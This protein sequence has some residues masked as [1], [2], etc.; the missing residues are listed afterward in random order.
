VP[1]KPLGT[2]MSE[3]LVE[4]TSNNF[5]CVGIVDR[6]GS[7]VGIITDGDLRRHMRPDLITAPVDEI[8]TKNPKTI[9][10]E[11]LASEALEILNSGKITTL[12]VTSGRKPIGILRLHDLL[13]AGV[14]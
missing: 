14:A 13:H 10:P 12:I 2:S 11:M 8:M 5:G 1:L 7:I 4:M 6:E 9:G 3:A